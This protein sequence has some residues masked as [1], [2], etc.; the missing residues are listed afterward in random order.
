MPPPNF[1]SSRTSPII[2]RNLSR[3]FGRTDNSS[4][5]AENVVKHE[6]ITT[7]AD[8]PKFSGEP[9]TIDLHQFIKR[10]ETL[11]AN[12]GITDEKLKIEVFKQ[13]ID[14]VKGSARHVIT[15]GNLES[16]NKFQEFVQVFRKHFTAKSDSDPLRAMVKYLQTRNEPNENQ[17][18]FIARL[19]ANG[20]DLV[21]IFEGSEW[22]AEGNTKLI[23][24]QNMVRILMLAQVIRAN[25]GVVQE[26]LYKDLKASVQLGEVDW[27]IKGYAEIDPA[28]S[29]YVLP[30][31]SESQTPPT[32]RRPRPKSRGR[33]ATPHRGRSSSRQRGT[34]QCYRCHKNGHTAK[35]CYAK[36]ICKNCQYPGHTEHNCWNA[37]WCE[38]HQYTGHR[39]QDCRSRSGQNFQ[40]GQ[41]SQKGTT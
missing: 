16:V 35:E 14:A 3:L 28:C 26:R 7:V 39:T 2:T 20:R 23:S 11:I 37:P 29:A 13:N 27:M 17:T 10:I 32:Q 1:V 24:V 5:M 22:A 31:R 8:I 4:K 15:Y 18:A 9:D 21:Q 12:K 33:A 19:D 6:I 30:V 25:K 41:R 38:Y 36:V 40:S 34:L